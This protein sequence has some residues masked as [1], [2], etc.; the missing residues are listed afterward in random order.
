MLVQTATHRVRAR[1]ECRIAATVVI[2]GVELACVATDISIGGARVRFA[3]APDVVV[4]TVVTLLMADH[5][6]RL[7]TV[8]YVTGTV[9]GVAFETDQPRA[10]AEITPRVLSRD[11]Q[12]PEFVQDRASN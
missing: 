8:R 6:P 4:G 12:C 1:Y 5:D 11:G 10:D 9:I 7:G 3:A 2:N